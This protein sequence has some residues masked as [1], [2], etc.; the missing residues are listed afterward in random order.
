MRR[1]FSISLAILVVMFAARGVVAQDAQQDGNDLLLKILKERNIL[2]EQEY[3]DIKGQ[4]ATEKNTVDQKLTVLDRSI[5]DYLAKAG[6]KTAGGTSYIQ[7]QGVTFESPDGMFSIF[8]GGLLQIGYFFDSYKVDNKNGTDYDGCEGKFAVFDNR[9]DFGGNAF[10]KNLKFYTQIQ[11]TYFDTNDGYIIPA[12]GMVGYS[13]G[14]VGAL[15]VLDAYFDYQFNDWAGIQVGEFKIPYGRQS[16]TDQ[17]DRAFGHIGQVPSYFRLGW[18]GRDTGAMLHGVSQMDDMSNGM[19][20]EWA[21]GLWNGMGFGSDNNTS[22]MW[23]GR[24][25]VYPFGYIPMV[26]GDWSGSQDFRFG[27]AASY[28]RDNYVL[29]GRPNPVLNAYQFEVVATF[30]GLY[31]LGEYFVH[32]S[33]DGYGYTGSGS[34]TFGDVDECGWYVQAGFMLMPGEFEVL[35][36]FG[37]IDPDPDS[38]YYGSDLNDITEW[39][40]GAAWYLYGHELKVLGEVGETI[41]DGDNYDSNDWFIRFGVQLD[42]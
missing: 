5:A 40:I 35:G 17:S 25:G 14:S 19:A 13:S 6:D 1:A 12:D 26:E 3:Q 29:N 15:T 24:V 9:F 37:M 33:Q 4:L 16:M 28:F 42:W 8:F 41:Y 27:V 31:F 30:G 10:D 21:A 38:G 34:G 22:L 36:R 7:N 20:I 32:D 2:S 23:G 11:T 18:Q 39:A